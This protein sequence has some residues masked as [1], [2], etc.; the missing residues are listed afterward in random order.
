MNPNKLAALSCAIACSIAGMGVSA[1]ARASLTMSPMVQPI[2]QALYTSYVNLGHTVVASTNLNRLIAGGTFNTT[3]ASMY[4]GSIQDGRTLTSELI[5]QMNRL[6]VTIPQWLPATREMPGFVDVPE[7]TTI[8]C[9]YAW[10][11]FAKEPTYSIG[12]PG[13][14]ITVGGAEASENSSVPFQM[15]QPMGDADPSHGCL[16]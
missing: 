5:G 10:T 14:G 16:H 4:T 15:Y 8:S 7:G 13:V 12:L 9:T 2:S 1:P 6:Y 3:C 11:A